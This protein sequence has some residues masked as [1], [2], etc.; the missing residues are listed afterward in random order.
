MFFPSF[1]CFFQKIGIQFSWCDY[2]TADFWCKI[3]IY[4]VSFRIISFA[5]KSIILHKKHPPMDG[6]RVLSSF[7]G[8]SERVDPAQQV[9]GAVVQEESLVMLIVGLAAV[10]ADE[11]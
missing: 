5:N 7:Q 1:F 8:H 6:W 3:A 10:A 4:N 2:S 9:A 11:F